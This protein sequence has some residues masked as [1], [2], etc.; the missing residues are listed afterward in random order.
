MGATVGPVGDGCFSVNLEIRDEL[1]T[2]RAGIW[3]V[4]ASAFPTEAEARLVDTLRDDGDAVISLVA[5]LDG[6]V[7]G[8]VLF[9]RMQ[10]PEGFLGLAPVAVAAAHR[11]QGIA[12]V[13]IREGL[14]RARRDGWAGVFVLGD[15][16]YQRFG[17]DRALAARFSSPYAGPHLMALSLQPGELPTRSGPAEY[18]RAFSQP[19]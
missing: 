2:D 10:S 16:Y 5:A 8:H 4:H 1:G 9:S 11:K 6:A 7:I 15:D 3:N 19:G 14:E 12:A 17:F 13:L 18:P